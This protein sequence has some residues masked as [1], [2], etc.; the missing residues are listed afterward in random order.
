M[1]ARLALA[2]L[3]GIALTMGGLWLERSLGVRP[4][5]LGAA[6]FPDAVSGAWFCPHGGGEGWRVWVIAANP[7]DRP[8]ELVIDAHGAT[9]EAATAKLEPRT[10]RY[11]SIEAE[12]I[13]AGTVVEFF[14]A[15]ATASM[16]VARPDGGGVAAEPCTQ[17]AA[18]RWYVP[19]GTSETE[20]E[21][22]N[23]VVMNPTAVDAVVDIVVTTER[24]TLRPGSLQGLVLGPG[25]VKGF[26]LNRFSLGARTVSAR[27]NAVVGRVAVAGIGLSEGGIRAHIGVAELN[28]RWFLPGAGD[29]GRGELVVG[30]G[31][32]EVPFQAR[33]QGLLEQIPALEQGTIEAG[34]IRTITVPTEEGA[35]VVEAEGPV[36]FVAARRSS[37]SGVG[38][39]E[40]EDGSPAPAQTP[41]PTPTPTPSP[42]PTDGGGASPAPSPSPRPSPTRD[43]TDRDRAPREGSRSSAEAVDRA[44]TTGAPAPA[45]TWVVP[46]ATGP[47]GGPAA[48]VIQNPGR[49]VIRARVTLVGAQGEVGEELEAV[50]VPAGRLV[51]IEL[52]D[53]TPEPVTA[54]VEATGGVVAAQVSLAPRA[55]AVS[56]GSPHFSVLTDST[57]GI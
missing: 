25:R 12:T 55:Y 3:L 22:A 27:V 8:S 51:V 14:G 18:D 52:G 30:A 29:G 38:I 45:A 48:L 49:G 35:L 56:L 19:D 31:G 6:T 40:P 42:T 47:E 39:E 11:L 43:R 41:S 36:G 5:V 50:E 20:G 1:R 24:E 2:A 17:R 13:S 53:L 44:S 34:A 10:H 4:V 28:R 33:A 32:T 9:A 57:P 37:F 15:P 46:P 16:I 23:V 21:A 7:S 26:D 54:L